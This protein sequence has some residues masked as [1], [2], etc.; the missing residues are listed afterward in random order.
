MRNWRRNFR[1]SLEQKKKMSFLAF[2]LKVKRMH[3]TYAKEN[4][5]SHGLRVKKSMSHSTARERLHTANIRPRATKPP[6]KQMTEQ[7]K[8]MRGVMVCG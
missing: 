7:P 8:R 5:G 6:I 1:K 3:H 2:H 4:E